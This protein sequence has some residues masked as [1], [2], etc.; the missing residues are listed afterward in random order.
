M[1]EAAQ[2]QQDLMRAGIT[3]FAW[4]INQSLAR[5][6]TCDPLLALRGRNEEPYIREV[7]NGLATRT[8]RLPWLPREPRGADGLAQLLDDEIRNEVSP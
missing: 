7:V 2:L 1:H 5:L 6:D 3:P 8:V 4:I